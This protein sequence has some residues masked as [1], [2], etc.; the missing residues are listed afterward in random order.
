MKQRVIQRMTV[1]GCI[2]CLALIDVSCRSESIHPASS[3]MRVSWLL[4]ELT[5]LQ[6]SCVDQKGRAC[7]LSEL[8]ITSGTWGNA[9]IVSSTTIRFEE[10]DITVFLNGN[11]YCALAVPSRLSSKF[12]A[13]WINVQGVSA[14]IPHPWKDI[15]DICRT[16]R[17]AEK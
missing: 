5:K 11:E 4:T 2:M 12:N 7:P 1:V 6:Q 17:R 15:P 9:D 10:Y 16:V 14:E 3:V 8:Q 13:I